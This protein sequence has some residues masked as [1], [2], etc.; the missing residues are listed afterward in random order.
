MTIMEAIQ[1][2][3]SLVGNTYQQEEKIE[4]LS[5][6]DSRI[7]QTII[8]TH[9]DPVAFSGYD[10]DTPTDTALLACPPY[11]ELYLRWMEAQVFYHNGEFKKY[12]NAIILFNTAFEDFQ[13]FYNRTHMPK[14]AGS[15]FLF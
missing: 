2:L 8:D 13:N 5:R 12:N 9:E 3:N 11:D 14:N 10:A 4:W 6:V 15:R 1:R 7:K